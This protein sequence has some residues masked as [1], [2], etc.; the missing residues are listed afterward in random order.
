[1]K[2]DT[3]SINLL[4]HSLS[5]ASSL[6]VKKIEFEKKG[7]YQKALAYIE[8]YMT[9]NGYDLVNVHGSEQMYVFHLIKR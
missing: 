8:D 3:I 2:I 6:E 1:M 7:F 4:A 5:H 9:K